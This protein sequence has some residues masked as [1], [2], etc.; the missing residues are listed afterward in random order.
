MLNRKKQTMPLYAKTKPINEYNQ[1]IDRFEK[2]A[3]I[4]IVIS[5]NLVSQN[6]TTNSFDVWDYTHTA[7]TK[8]NLVKKGMRIGDSLIVEQVVNNNSGYY[9]TLK[10]LSNND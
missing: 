5:L 9:L 6:Y 2:I 8:S 10:E 4:D 7:F 1:K 3:D